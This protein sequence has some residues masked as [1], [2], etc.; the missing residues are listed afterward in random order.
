[1]GKKRDKKYGF[2]VILPEKVHRRLE[3]LAE[4]E[5]RPKAQM[6]RVLIERALRGGDDENKTTPGGG[7]E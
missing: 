4:Y 6:A 5:I 7:D 3:A 1:M 2:T